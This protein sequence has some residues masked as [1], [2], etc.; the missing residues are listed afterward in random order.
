MLQGK[1]AAAPFAQA[2]ATLT[3][4]ARALGLLERPAPRREGWGFIPRSADGAASRARPRAS[5]VYVAPPGEAT[6][7]WWAPTQARIEALVAQ[8]EEARAR[9]EWAR[10]DE[11]RADLE[12]MGTRIE[13]TPAGT[14]WK[15]KSA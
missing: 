7:E 8:R 11:I 3:S 4:H 6:A 13:D 10:A 9:R 14:R 2:L 12:Q 15:W 1:R 5:H